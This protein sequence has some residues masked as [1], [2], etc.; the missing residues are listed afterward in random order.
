MPLQTGCWQLNSPLLCPATTTSLDSHLT[1]STNGWVPMSG[2]LALN[3]GGGWKVL[4]LWTVLPSFTFQAG[5]LPLLSC[6]SYFSLPAWLLMCG[7]YFFFFFCCYPLYPGDW[8][9][10]VCLLRLR[11]ASISLC[12]LSFSLLLHLCSSCTLTCKNSVP[13]LEIEELNKQA[14]LSQEWEGREKNILFKALGEL[15][16]GAVSWPHCSCVEPWYV[17]SSTEACNTS[18]FYFSVLFCRADGGSGWGW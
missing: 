17:K 4:S 5:G 10:V 15:I 12:P 7:I 3:K 18:H 2:C 1:Q 13:V 6:S 9:T 11:F 16:A 8:W 14:A